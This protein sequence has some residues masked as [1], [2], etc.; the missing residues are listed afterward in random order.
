[1]LIDPDAELRRILLAEIG[2]ITSF[3]AV[4]ASIEDCAVPETLSG[5]VPLCRP[6]KTKVVRAALPAG[7]ELITLPIRSPNAWLNPWL[8]APAASLVGDQLSV[9]SSQ[10]FVVAS[11]CSWIA[12]PGCIGMVRGM[13]S[14]PGT[15]LKV[16]S[17]GMGLKP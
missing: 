2:Q 15:K 16:R 7:M 12:W 14:K 10:L 4:G 3:P 8:P 11:R 17:F 5:A 6:S 9:A 13:A 1:M